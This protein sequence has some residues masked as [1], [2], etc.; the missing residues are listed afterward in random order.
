MDNSKTTEEK[1]NAISD[2]SNE[3]FDKC[4]LENENVNVTVNAQANNKFIVASKTVE[5]NGYLAE[6][7]GYTD[8]VKMEYQLS[9]FSLQHMNMYT[10]INSQL[11][12][13]KITLILV[14]ASMVH[15][16]QRHLEKMLQH[17]CIQL[18]ENIHIMMNQ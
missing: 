8:A 9:V 11:Q 7:Y 12:Q 3:N 10:E 15:L 5:V 18:M 16:F 13:Q 17:L 6:R 14:Q 1:I 4:I 2:I